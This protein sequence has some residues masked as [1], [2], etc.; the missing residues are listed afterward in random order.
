MKI[1]IVSD[2]H[3]R[4]ARL[5]AAVE[6]L[7]ARGVDALVHCGD[8]G[9]SDCIEALAGAAPDVYVVAGNMDRRVEELAAAAEPLGIHF[10]W[11]VVRVPLGGGRCLVATH[12]HDER[13]LS[14]LIRHEQFPYVCHGHTHRPR[15]ERRGAVRIIN[16]GALHNAHTYRI[17]VLDTDADTLQHL[18]VPP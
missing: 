1:G 8:V 12:G 13:I 18:V 5:R 10:A 11:E 14:E 7:T 6:L 17:A 4:A 2:S 3:G 9:T 16:P 15:D